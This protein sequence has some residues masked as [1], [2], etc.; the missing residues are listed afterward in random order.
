MCGAFRRGEF[1]GR[2]SGRGKT[3][4]IV[5]QS[6]EKVPRLGAGPPFD[7]AGLVRGGGFGALD[8]ALGVTIGRF[9]ITIGRFCALDASLSIA[10]GRFAIAVGGFRALDTALSVAVGGFAVAVGG[11]RALDTSH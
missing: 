7:G 10:V 3:R 2:R 9:A 11:F 4:E 6:G 1:S 8:A 5:A